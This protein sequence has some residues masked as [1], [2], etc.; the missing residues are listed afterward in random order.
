M[1]PTEASCGISW[2]YDKWRGFK[3]TATKYRALQSTGHCV[4]TQTAED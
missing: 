3:M 1:E 2:F 4:A